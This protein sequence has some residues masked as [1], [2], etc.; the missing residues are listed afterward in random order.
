MATLWKLIALIALLMTPLAMIMPAAAA[1]PQH[2]TGATSME[3]CAD[4]GDKADP[5]GEVPDCAMACSA[6]LP[7]ADLV[8]P[9]SLPIMCTP[10]ASPLAQLLRGIHP[11]TATPPP[12]RT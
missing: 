8:Q 7:A 9:H 3:H 4:A 11:E 2:S 6:A 1:V 12:K 10:A 5:K